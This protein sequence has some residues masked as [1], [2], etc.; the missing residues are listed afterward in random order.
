MRISRLRHDGQIVILPLHLVHRLS[1]LAAEGLVLIS[2]DSNGRRL[3]VA[4]VRPRSAVD[5]ELAHLFVEDDTL[6][7]VHGLIKSINFILVTER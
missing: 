2:S 6:A 4:V 5:D 1:E 3:D 7:L